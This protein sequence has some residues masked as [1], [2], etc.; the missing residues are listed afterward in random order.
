MIT[1]V[2]GEEDGLELASIDEEAQRKQEIEQAGFTLLKGFKLHFV[3]PETEVYH[4]LYVAKWRLKHSC[5]P[6]P[7]PTPPCVPSAT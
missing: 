7:P 6:A 4:I 3:A 5:E 1:S 2:R